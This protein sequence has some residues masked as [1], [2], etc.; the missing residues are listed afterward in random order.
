MNATMSQPGNTSLR[1]QT[2]KG[3]S[4]EEISDTNATMLFFFSPINM[5]IKKEA[6]KGLGE[7]AVRHATPKHG[8]CTL[9]RTC[10]QHFVKSNCPLEI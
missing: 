6:E 5:N 10:I 8:M 4:H 1:R 3:S 7:I 2:R 9:K